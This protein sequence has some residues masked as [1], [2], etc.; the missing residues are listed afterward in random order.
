MENSR[1]DIIPQVKITLILILRAAPRHDAD[2]FPP[3]LPATRRVIQTSSI[4][5]LKKY[6][7]KC[8]QSF[9]YCS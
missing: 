4:M 9:G 5:N 2:T 1:Q 6:S 8:Y 3:F 7:E